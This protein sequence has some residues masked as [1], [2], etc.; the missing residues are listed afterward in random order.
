MTPAAAVTLIKAKARALG[1]DACGLATA[2]AVSPEAARDLQQWLD[3]GYAADMDYMHRNRELRLDPRLLQPGART[4]IV[5]ALNY[6]PETPSPSDL[7]FSYYAYG[8]DYHYVIRGLL[9]ELLEYIRT[10]IAPAL[11]PG[12]ELD[13]RPFTDSAPL[14]ERY[15]AVR[16]GLGFIG[17][18]R[19]LILPGRGSYFFLGTLAINLP[20]PADRP[21][22]IG[23]GT[24]RRC[25][26]ACPTGALQF[27]GTQDD[28]NADTL[29]NSLPQQE[30]TTL[31]ARRCISYQ[32]IENR[33]DEIPADVAAHLAGR[34]YGC[35]ACQQACPWNRFARPTQVEA[36]RPLP[37][38]LQLDAETL[39]ALGGGGFKRLFRHSAIM[40][41]GYKGLLRNLRYVKP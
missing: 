22:H 38:F 17:R 26:D 12:V 14:M 34:I 9:S 3:A 32:T 41:A 6:Y 27:I 23:C 8:A 24:C 20:L 15:W 13:G 39:R 1:F 16:A 33:T 28:G 4:L 10:D 18:N 31:D 36:F 21:L 40:R 2:E 7:Q 29:G 5:T 35:D 11:M 25:L 19:L 30:Q 37:E